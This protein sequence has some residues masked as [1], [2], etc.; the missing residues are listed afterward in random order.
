MRPGCPPSL[1][2]VP[3]GQLIKQ[4]GTVSAMIYGLPRSFFLESW[5]AALFMEKSRKSAPGAGSGSALEDEDRG[6]GWGRKGK[7]LRVPGSS[8]QAPSPACQCAVEGR[9]KSPCPFPA[10]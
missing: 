7:V 8:K 10:S 4:V 3:W 5:A 6:K 9:C 2:E 1:A